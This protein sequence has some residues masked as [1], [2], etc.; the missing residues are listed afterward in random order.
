MI[1]FMQ[2]NVCVSSE[3]FTRITVGLQANGNFRCNSDN[4]CNFNG[5]HFE[6]FRVAK[7]AER[8]QQWRSESIVGLPVKDL[9]LHIYLQVILCFSWVMK[10]MRKNA[11]RNGTKYLTFLFLSVIVYSKC[12]L[13]K[14]EKLTENLCF[15]YFKAHCFLG[16]FLYDKTHLI[17]I[18]YVLLKCRLYLGAMVSGFSSSGW[19]EHEEHFIQPYVIGR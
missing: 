14:H 9:H 16:Q 19:R 11:Q 4:F 15:L 2:G 3:V 8:V 18:D 17:Y 12:I 13:H 5:G 1:H 6:F 7:L 10:K